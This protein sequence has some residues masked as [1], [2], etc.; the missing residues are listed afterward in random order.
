MSGTL[1]RL[2]IEPLPE[3]AK[4]VRLD[5]EY[6]A[7]QGRSFA[8]WIN[9]GFDRLIL[10]SGTQMAPGVVLRLCV[11]GGVACG[12]SLFVATENL[13]ATASA[14]AAGVVLP[15]AGLFVARARRQ[16]K[17]RKQ[18][19]LLLDGLAHAA[20][21][22]RSVADGLEAASAEMSAPL[23]DEIGRVARRLRM[24]IGLEAALDDLPE[25]TGLE[26]VQVIKSALA[27]H[28]RTGCDLVSLLDRLTQTVAAGM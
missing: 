7:P 18:L 17:I 4:I 11:L 10:Q 24:G 8:T 20:R 5:E 13:L 14:L 1:E 15:I 16:R 6:A 19:P 23:A 12:G 26:S 2:R 3:F 9:G 25:R 21:A 22:G 27:A 28:D